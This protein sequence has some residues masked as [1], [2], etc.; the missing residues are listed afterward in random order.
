MKTIYLLLLCALTMSACA[1]PVPVAVTCPPPPPVPAV[2][3]ESPSTGPSLMQQYDL[4][5]KRFREL[6]NKATRPE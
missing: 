2:L 5:I 3:T 4:S 1:T 6:L